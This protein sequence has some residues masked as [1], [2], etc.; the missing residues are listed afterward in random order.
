M[1]DIPVRAKDALRE[2]ALKKNYIFTVYNFTTGY[3]LVDSIDKTE[4]YTTRDDSAVMVKAESLFIL[5]I[6]DNGVA[7]TQT[8]TL[9]DDDL[10]YVELS[11]PNSGTLLRVPSYASGTVDIYVY[12]SVGQWKEYTTIDNN[13]LVKESVKFDERMC[14]GSQLKF[15]LCEGTALE[16]QYFDRDNINGMRIYAVVSVQYY[17]ENDTEQWQSVPMGWYEVVQCPMQFS[18]GIRKAVAYNKLRSSYLDQN[19]T[20]YL[21]DYFA[22]RS[23]AYFFEVR[24]ALTD[25][26]ELDTS[27]PTVFDA[28]PQFYYA[29]VSN[30]TYTCVDSNDAPFVAS[31]G[32][33]PWFA[34][35]YYE[36]TLDPTEAYRFYW[37]NGDA[38]AF[39]E[40][41]YQ[42]ISDMLDIGLSNGSTDRTA[43]INSILSS[44]SSYNGCYELCGIEMTK[45]DDTVEI[46]SKKAYDNNL[47]SASGTMSDAIGRY[48]VGYKKIRIYIP[49]VFLMKPDAMTLDDY[50]T[51]DASYCGP[52][53][54]G[55]VS[56]STY[57][58]GLV[59]LESGSKW[60][61]ATT[62]LPATARSTYYNG[63]NLFTSN[64]VYENLDT[65]VSKSGYITLNFSNGVTTAEYEYMNYTAWRTRPISFTEIMSADITEMTNAGD[66]L[67]VD[68]TDLGDITAREAV[69]AIY[70]LSACYGKLDRM[71]DFFAPVELN[72]SRLLPADDLYPDDSL[73][74]DGNSLNGN[75]SMY[76]KLWTD[77]QGVQT[78]KYLI[79]TYKTLDENNNEIETTLQRTVNADG[80]TNY[81]CS[82]NWL[83]RNLV[84][85]EN[86]VGTYADAM[87]L[88]MRN[89]SWF[90]FEMWCAG[91]PYL[92]T[93]DEIEITNS[94]GTFTSYILSRQLNGIQN[95]QDT[96]INGELDVF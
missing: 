26:F 36:M 13:N 93:G 77:S 65:S 88:K 54:Y 84:W 38:D 37:L 16:F 69:S 67:V 92:E 60:A 66:Q 68:L 56:G 29:K 32:N 76:S 58:Y 78:F 73:Y 5:A 3:T 33:K 81:N 41:V 23:T 34:S 2:G 71:T 21:Q 45:E 47:Y 46:Y 9:G 11:N 63:F 22:G 39:E 57:G 40:S 48:F 79:I 14:S 87:V 4:G 18:T 1:I 62:P 90:P 42:L 72:N 64:W 52:F 86:D 96:Y 30:S 25:D 70:E 53:L 83:F 10:Y 7:T 24:K 74:P 27:V 43:V 12:D 82:D 8:A 61:Y 95:L 19:T 55:T 28:T 6:Q 50:S 31:T 59:Y 85:N 80:T 15:G 44:Y 49:F 20:V 91:L 17:D 94:E 75:P 35:A 89:V 51:I